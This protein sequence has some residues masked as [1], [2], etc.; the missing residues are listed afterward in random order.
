[1]KKSRKLWKRANQN[2]SVDQVISNRILIL[3]LV[4]G[5][6]FL[7]IFLRLFY[8]QIFSYNDYTAKRED[9]T[10]I[11]QY[12][13][14]PR[15]QIYDCKGRILAKTVVSHNIVF[16]SPNNMDT[17]DYKLYAKRIVKVFNVSAKDFTDEDKKEAYI[18]Y[19]SFLS[20]T[21]PE[22]GANHLLTS[23]ELK[24]Y[25]SGAWGDDAESKRHQILMK[26]I[27][28]K[29]IGEMTQSTLKMCVIYQR[30]TANQ[31]TGQENVVLEDVS[32]D[33]VA[34][35]VEHK[36][37]FPGFDVDFGGWKREYPYGES[38]SD[39]LG[40]VTTSTQG[41]PSELASY[42][43]AK[44][45][46]YNASVGK[47]GL[48]Y[49][50]NDLLAGTPE[51]AKITYDS[52]GLA[53]KEVIQEAKK[54]YDIHL[55]I[56]IDMQT[57]L[58]D[59]IKN[60]LSEYGGTKNRENF[61]SLF[62]TILNPK[63]GSVLA[64][65]GYQMDLDTKKMTYYASGNY[66]SLVN[67]GSCIK[68]ATVYMGESEGVV[69]PGEVIVDKVMNIGGQEFGSYED[70]GP[71]DDVSALQVSSNVYMF[72]VAIRLAGATYVEEQP[73]AVADLQGSLNKMRSYYSM[74]GLG[75]VTGLDIPNESSGYMGHGSE[76]GMLLN[77]SIGQFDMYS[78]IQLAVYATTIASDGNL[79]QPR[80]MQYAT[81]VNSSE[82]V[83]VNET[84]IKST[85]PEKNAAYLNRVKQGF[86]ACVAGGYCGDSLKDYSPNVSAKTGTAEV[87]DWTTANLVGYAPS[88]NPTMSFA[89]S[90]PTSSQNNQSV[91]PNICANTVMPQA[92]QKYFELYPAS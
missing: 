90:A 38:L 60:T 1:M 29:Q 20:S 9:Y 91:A 59:I 88:E 24:Q 55:S 13:S 23:K 14:A 27:G 76:P 16:T 85:L 82:V 50:Y 45:Y 33:D 83:D 49:Q 63:D 43:L 52:K 8:L 58:D 54:G 80:F 84:K 86:R 89:C 71:V 34:Y 77:Y 11:K 44:G 67:P 57:S 79:Y 18:T 53:Q 3:A 32:D 46:Q 36:T 78:P 47:S 35:L 28:K 10:S 75:N 31:S 70:H 68:G 15:G 69:S 56:D 40:S 39:V 19:K 21:N 73:L 2:V 51:I 22:Y 6:C 30:M 5:A 87:G 26:R 37:D 62:T 42:Y 41:L 12:T 92:I 81:E 72:N 17:D 61:Q 25:K 4:I 7:V 65:S 74:F 64:M 48:E 66:A